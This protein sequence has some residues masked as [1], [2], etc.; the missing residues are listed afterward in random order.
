V[1]GK[2][3]A[4]PSA[5]VVLYRDKWE[6]WLEGVPDL[7]QRVGL[8]LVA[9]FLKCFEGVNRLIALE[10][11]VRFNEEVLQRRLVAFDRNKRTI[12]LFLGSTMYEVGEALQDLGGQVKTGQSRTGQNRPVNSR[13]GSCTARSVR[14]ASRP[15]ASSASCAVRT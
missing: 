14:P 6:L 10:Q 4:T 11:L 5:R 2:P 8:D 3:R 9:A 1:G 12:I 13:T 15:V 7:C